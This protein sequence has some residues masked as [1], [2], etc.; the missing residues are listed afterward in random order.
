MSNNFKFFRLFQLCC[1]LQLTLPKNN[2]THKFLKNWSILVQVLRV[3]GHLWKRFW[4]IRKDFAFLHYFIIINSF[5]TLGTKL[6]YLTIFLLNSVLYSDWQCKWNSCNTNIK[7]A[8]TL[9]SLFTLQSRFTLQS[10]LLNPIFP[11]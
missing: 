8:K 11:K 1:Y 3:I 2:I 4:T 7:T 9:Q 10:Q 6:N 5:Q